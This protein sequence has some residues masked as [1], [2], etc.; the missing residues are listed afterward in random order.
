[1]QEY[2]LA[3]TKEGNTDTLITLIESN[4]IVGRKRTQGRISG[5]TKEEAICDHAKTERKKGAT[6]CHQGGP[7]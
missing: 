3:H 4:D 1:M 7:N 6:Y 2:T 5:N